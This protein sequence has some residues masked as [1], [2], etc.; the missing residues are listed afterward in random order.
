MGACSRFMIHPSSLWCR[1]IQFV[2]WGENQ[3]TQFGS[4]NRGRRENQHLG[5]F[6]SQT[7]NPNY[8]LNNAIV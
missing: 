3:D 6:N 7:A 2:Q 1:P 5:S 8:P 4:S